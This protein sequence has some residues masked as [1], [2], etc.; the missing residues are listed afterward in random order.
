M[1]VFTFQHANIGCD[2]EFKDG[3]TTR[4]GHLLLYD[5]GLDVRTRGAIN[6]AIGVGTYG[7]YAYDEVDNK[8]GYE[9]PWPV[10]IGV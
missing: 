7:L 3:G 5:T 4:K 1:D 8:W 10:I 6:G 2:M 9:I